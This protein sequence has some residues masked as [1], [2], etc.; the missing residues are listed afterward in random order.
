MAGQFDTEQVSY[1]SKYTDPKSELIPKKLQ[2]NKRKSSEQV[3]PGSKYIVLKSKNVP[4]E[5]TFLLKDGY[6]ART[7]STVADF[8]SRSNSNVMN[9]SLSEE[10]KVN[11]SLIEA[12]DQKTIE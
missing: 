12:E 1:G 6:C 3:L 7:C 8:Y 11:D 5:Q 2:K 9:S 10:S 4:K